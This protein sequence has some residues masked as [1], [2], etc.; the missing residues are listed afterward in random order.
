MEDFFSIIRDGKI[1]TEH[2]VNSFMRASHNKN[3]ES[4]E[5]YFIRPQRAGASG[6][7]TL[8]DFF[9]ARQEAHANILD[10]GCGIGTLLLFLEKA[11]QRPFNY[12]G[13]DVSDKS[14]ELASKR[15]MDQPSVSFVEAAATQLPFADHSYDFV[16]S[17][18]ALMLMRPA[19][20]VL[21]EISRVLKAGGYLASVVPCAWRR[22]AVFNEL[23]STKARAAIQ[24]IYPNFHQ[25]LGGFGQE[26]FMSKDSVARLFSE[27]G[28][29]SDVEFI[30]FDVDFSGLGDEIVADL[31]SLYPFEVA[32][33]E[34][35]AKAL[36]DFA[37]FVETTYGNDNMIPCH[38]PFTLIHARKIK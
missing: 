28:Q 25:N 36:A 13:I 8:A 20:K 31:A 9:K 11:I 3:P 19:R 18:M 2:Q 12:S 37:E 35:K 27:N 16:L 26:E 22:P 15:F 29:F 1:P 33:K 38:R 34:A 32:S 6:Y 30:E 7:E 23:L 5:K 17:H 21:L 24:S 10:L 14:I 4:C